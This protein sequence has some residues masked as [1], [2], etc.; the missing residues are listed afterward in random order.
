[1][2]WLNYYWPITLFFVLP[3]ILFG[4]P[5]FLAIRYGGETFSRFA[6]NASDIPIWGKLWMMAWGGLIAGLFVHFNGW[7]VQ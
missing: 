3:F 4:L 5:E 6:R 1:M 7:C 2:T